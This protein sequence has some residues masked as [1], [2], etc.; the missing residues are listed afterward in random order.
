MPAALSGETNMGTFRC[1]GRVGL[2]VVLAAALLHGGT[3]CLAR[4]ARSVQPAWAQ[5]AVP[6]AYEALLGDDAPSLARD[7]T[8]L[9]AP[10]G[11]DYLEAH[12]LDRAD[13][14]P[15]FA[16]D[17]D[18][19]QLSVAAGDVASGVPLLFQAVAS[20]EPNVVPVIEVYG[21]F[22]LGD[23]LPVPH[24]PLTQPAPAIDSMAT[25]FALGGDWFDHEGASLL[26][27]PTESGRYYVRVRPYGDDS[28]SGYR[29][30]AG[31]YTFRVKAG[32]MVRLAGSDRYE[33]AV[34]ISRER[35]ADAMLDGALGLD[36]LSTAVVASGQNYPDALAGS[37]LAGVVNGP[38]LLTR[39]STLPTVTADELRRLAPDR[40]IVLGG[41]GAV[42]DDVLAQIS[43]LFPAA[44]KPTVTRSAG[45]DR[46]DTAV[47]IAADGAA[48]YASESGG[49]LPGGCII[50]NARNFPDALSASSAAAGG[51]LPI[52]LTDADALDQ[53]VE[54]AM[55]SLGVR[56]AIIVGGTGVV[57]SAVENRL[58]SLLG[59]D[60]VVRLAGE[61]RYETSATFAAWLAGM[62]A[63]TTTVGTPDT[64]DLMPAA[65]ALDFGVATGGNF[66]DALA[67]GPSC[68]RGTVSHP[69]AP[70]LLTPP[71][72][73]S[74]WILNA[75]QLPSGSS[76]L[77]RAWA[78]SSDG[79][80]IG[81][82][83]IFGGSS[84]VSD[85]T[86]IALDQASGS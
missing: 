77:E 61:D 67:A 70:L 31:E 9:V 48:L 84:A 83:Y 15:P 40:V 81:E 38:I 65:R 20:G 6:D 41:A 47:Q 43:A 52:L 50:A 26:F 64:P 27:R 23:P 68:G 75:G 44:E 11:S 76:Y 4:P 16:T 3:V 69:A 12:T 22:G 51:L 85:S 28:G 73:T 59:D 54:G 71:T 74:A 57:S 13:S 66:P 37:F 79:E 56:D 5:A 24:D 33:T 35:F 55:T 78:L 39:A 25:A 80:V 53:R 42:S 60:H 82:S 17:E 2:A 58:A 62:P 1:L 86:W 46:I 72:S 21:P 34:A 19:F 14:A 49:T 10:Y 45:P 32:S 63:G 36:N 7:I 30:G 8:A 18:W 29:A